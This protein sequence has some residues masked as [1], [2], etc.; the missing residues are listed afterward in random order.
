MKR[1]EIV[2]EIG[3]NHGG[4]I[5]LAK[6]M[7]DVAKACGADVAK[8]QLY[9]PGSLLDK[10]N[11]SS[12]DWEVICSAELSRWSVDHLFGYCESVGIEFMASAF[13]LERLGWLEALDVKRHKIAS[14]SIYDLLYVEAV[15]NTNKPYIVSLGMVKDEPDAWREI[16]ERVIMT[17]IT[18][19]MLYCVSEYPA[20]LHH[21]ELPAFHDNVSR[22]FTGFSDHTVGLTAA[23]IAIAKG[24]GLIE[25]HFTFDKNVNGPDHAGSMNT[26]ELRQLCAFRDE[27][28]IITVL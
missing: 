22:G 21:V 24:A 9:S 5:S 15:Q 19:H 13:D 14:R 27:C 20:L 17:D 10:E 7:I 16:N 23:M 3:I 6:D 11:Y 1:C 25:K 28:S 26:V 4:I 2:A 12:S 8:F 18:Q